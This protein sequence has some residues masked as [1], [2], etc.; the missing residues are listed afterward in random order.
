MAV[1]LP[2]AD[3]AKTFLR[4]CRRNARGAQRLFDFLASPEAGLFLV[5][6]G[7]GTGKTTALLCTAA[8][9]GVRL[10]SC[11]SPEQAE[12][13]AHAGRCVLVWDG[14][15]GE[16]PPWK[17]LRCMAKVR[18]VVVVWGVLE[19]KARSKRLPEDGWAPFSGSDLRSKAITKRAAGARVQKRAAKRG[20]A[21]PSRAGRGDHGRAPTH[22]ASQT[23]PFE[24]PDEVARPLDGQSREQAWELYLRGGLNTA[25]GMERASEVADCLTMPYGAIGDEALAMGIRCHPPEGRIQPRRAAAPARSDPADLR[26]VVGGLE[27]RPEEASARAWIMREQ[28]L[29]TEN[30]QAVVAGALSL[31][32][33]S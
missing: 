24:E 3:Q 28:G 1:A 11:E 27:W 7:V 6:G 16:E 18:P 30:A 26:R 21:G 9:A 29:L 32:C 17:W 5:T 20:R 2:P 33:E 10:V 19:W 23:D 25:E 4:T 22:E 8:A 13:A 15:E 12:R 14:C 31:C